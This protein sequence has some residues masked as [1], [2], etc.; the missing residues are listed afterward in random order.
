M[1]A[2]IHHKPVVRGVIF[3]MDGTL[4]VPV[5]DFAAMRRRV[6]VG[7]TGDILDIIKTWDTDRQEQAKKILADIE[8]EALQRMQVMP[9]VLDLCDYLDE[10]RIPRA[11][12]TR[13]V[14]KSVRWFHAE[15]FCRP[16]ERGITRGPFI[17][18]YSREC[19]FPYKPNPGALLH[20]CEQWGIMPSEMI[21]IGDSAKDDVAAGNRAGGHTILL[22]T[23]AR[24]SLQELESSEDD[25]VS[26]VVF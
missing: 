2:K 20:V 23:D 22:D 17:P 13:N 8:E 12:I 4:T 7:Q 21:M 25:S 10:H 6:G 1:V 18:A 3:D 9:G 16:C 26:A 14:I 24:Y 11:L 5:I 15:H 19:G